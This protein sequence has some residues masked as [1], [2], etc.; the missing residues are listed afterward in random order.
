M[1]DQPPSGPVDPVTPTSPGAPQ[2]VDPIR[3]PAPVTDPLAAPGP[4]ARPVV[5]GQHVPADPVAPAQP[6]GWVWG[7]PAGPYPGAPYAGGPYPA[8]PYPGA[9]YPGWYPAGGGWDPNDPLVTPPHAGIGGWFAR[10]TGALRRGWRLLVPIMLLTQAA[11]AA[12]VSVLSLALAPS[13]EVAT[14]PDG[15]PVL[16]DGY[17]GD[18]LTFYVAV[19]AA[20]LLLGPVQSLGWAAGTW[21]VTRQAAD[22]PVGLGAAFRYGLRRLLGLWGWTLLSSLLIGLGAC[23]CL[24]P[25]IY[26]AFAFALVGPVYLFERENPIGRSFRIFHQ[27]VGMV[28]GRVALVAAALLLG[29][30]VGVVLEAVGQLPFGTHP[31]DSPGTAAGAVGVALL[32]A[33]L[34]VPVY[35]AQLVGLLATYAEQRAHEGPVNAARLAAELG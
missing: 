31:M 7:A 30:L 27:R 29:A 3:P 15:A 10:C 14:A 26:L 32:A 34:A 1:S 20:S 8:I 24:L 22:E 2:P 19:L 9:P 21:V 11:P 4:E 28:L 6:Q 33:V 12:V 13:G 16:P 17:F 5:S 25:G 23:F 35:L 18:V